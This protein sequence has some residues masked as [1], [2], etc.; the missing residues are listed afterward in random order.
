LHDCVPPSI[1][2]TSAV[3]EE[4]IERLWTTTKG[5][6][7]REMTEAKWEKLNE[8]VYAVLGETRGTNSDMIGVCLAVACRIFE[9]PHED[10]C[11]IAARNAATDR[12]GDK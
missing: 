10:G 7:M 5:K 12:D 3:C 6:V 11:S 4:A 2:E 9:E 8:K 1:W